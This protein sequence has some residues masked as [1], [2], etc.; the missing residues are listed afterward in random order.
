MVTH[1]SNF[2]FTLYSTIGR[3]RQVPR[4]SLPF[5]MQS[6]SDYKNCMK[7]LESVRKHLGKKIRSLQWLIFPAVLEN[8]IRNLPHEIL[9]YIFE[10][11]HHSTVG[12][13]FALRISQVSRRFRQIALQ[14]SM[15]WTRIAGNYHESRFRTFI[16]RSGIR[17]LE[18]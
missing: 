8:G 9:S 12:C 14:T 7:A 4:E 17:E 3:N 1:G 15:I 6:L 10:L 18:I 13:D 11:C 2:V 16:T 5:L